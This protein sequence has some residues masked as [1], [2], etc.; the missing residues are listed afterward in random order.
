ML[1]VQQAGR[2]LML[3]RLIGMAGVKRGRFSVTSLSRAAGLS[4]RIAS[5]A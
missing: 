1:G 3:A 4:A 5:V 2:F